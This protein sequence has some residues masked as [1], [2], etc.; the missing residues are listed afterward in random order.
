MCGITGF[1]INPSNRSIAEKLIA[2][3]SSTLGH[4][5]PDGWGTYLS[6]EMAIGHTR[7]SIVDL[8]VGQQP[9]LT[10]RYVIAYNGEIFNYIELRQELEQKGVCFTTTATPKSCSRRMNCTARTLYHV[11]R[12]VR[13]HPLGPPGKKSHRRP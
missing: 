10:D 7:L 9:M 6:P 13:H 2:A 1:L 3:M 8:A 5:G 11:Q 4:R 12:S